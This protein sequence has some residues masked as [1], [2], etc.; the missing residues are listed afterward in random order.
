MNLSME[1][2]RE[3]VDI[4]KMPMRDFTEAL[5][6]SGSKV[7]SYGEVGSEIDK[8][9]VGKI[10]SVDKHPDSD[11]L[12]VCQVDAGENEPLQIV[13]GADNVFAGALVPVALSGSSLPGGKKI[14]KGKLRGVVSNGMLCSL[15][16]LGLTKNDFPYAIEDGIFII[17]EDCKPGE[18]IKK[19]TGQDDTVVEFEITP[20]R[21]DCLS[22]IGLAREV[23]ATF[24]KKLNYPDTAVKCAS[25]KTT[26]FVNAAVHEKTLCT[27]YMARAVRNVKIGPSPLF[28]R[29]RLRNAGVRPINNIVDITNY[30]MLEYGQPMHAFDYR[31]IKGGTINVRL[32]KEG[33]KITTLDGTERTLDDRMLVIADCEKPVAVAGV[34]GGEFSGIMDDTNTIVFESAMFD[35]ASV[36]LTAKRLNMR[37]EASARYE[38]GLDAQNTYGALERA[39]RLVELLGIGDVCDDYIDID[40]SDKTPH[41]VLL[42]A[43][44][45]NRFLG[46]NI[47][48]QFMVDTLKKLE[49]KV[50]GDMVTAPS[51]RADIEQKPDIAEEV[52]RF[53]GYNTIPTTMIAGSARGGLTNEQN[54]EKSAFTML[55]G[56]GYSEVQTY[57]FISPKYYDKIKMSAESPLRSSVKIIN[58]LGE[59]T[60]IMRTTTLPSMLETLAFNYNNRNL[61]AKLFEIGKVYM[62]KGKD[63]LPDEYT[64]ISLGAYGKGIDFYSLKGDIEELIEKLGVNSSLIEYTP[65]KDDHAYHPGRC[66]KITINGIDTGILGEIHPEVQ[67]AYGIDTRTY[68]AIIDFNTVLEN[69]ADDKHY[70][71]LPKFPS[72]ARD[73][74]VTCDEAMTVMELEAAMK[75]AAGK[76]IEKIELFDIYRG[77]QIPEGKKSVAFS[78]I[79]RAADRTLT[80]NEADSAVGKVLKA[81]EKIGATLRS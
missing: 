37:T 18:D 40:N 41:K 12:V 13:T 75:A 48:K 49:F 64:K 57:S 20:N 28:I 22:V 50:E 23:A 8:V 71:P 4:D 36:R 31:Q 42:D 1:W 30:V 56:L 17:E 25:G 10:L 68:A 29:K 77:K 32:A 61:D 72:T 47:D 34:M 78:V 66:A 26:D 21:P 7:E 45:V 60:S 52:A 43:D 46:T 62:P 27:R 14:K 58:P 63:E 3:Y 5:T 33:E 38:K 6:M 35:A 9:V 54:F 2:L 79:M 16:E 59:D 69:K 24:D 74:A 65:Y 44:W 51:Y 19:V 53:Y 70:T 80:D 76:V 55:L 15:G 81:L 73:I 39:C 67:A 11:H